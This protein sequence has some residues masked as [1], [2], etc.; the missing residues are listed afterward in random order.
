M[1][2]RNKWRVGTLL[3]LIL[4]FTV[5]SVALTITLLEWN[6]QREQRALGRNAL[7]NESLSRYPFT[8]LQELTRA[9]IQEDAYAEADLVVEHVLD[10]YLSM[11]T[12]VEE[13]RYLTDTVLG[14]ELAKRPLTLADQEIIK[15]LNAE[16]NANPSEER[17]LEIEAELKRIHEEITSRAGTSQ[18]TTHI[19]R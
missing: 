1:K 10:Q 16:L 9:R 17:R 2:I 3:F 15:S 8:F 12:S 18:V 11:I 4:I 6:M 14:I 13:L 5:S 7:K 19:S